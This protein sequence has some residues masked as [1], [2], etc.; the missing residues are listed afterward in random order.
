M[1]AASKS[2]T[3]INEPF[4]MLEFELENGHKSTSNK[5]TRVVKCEMNR[6]K[7]AEMLATLETIQK[8]IDGLSG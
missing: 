6:N 3:E 5:S 8:Q 1:K 7:I 2:L 4:A